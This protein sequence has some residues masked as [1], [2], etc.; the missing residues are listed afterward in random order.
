MHPTTTQLTE[1]AH[2]LKNLYHALNQLKHHHQQPEARVMKARPGAQSPGNWLAVSCYVEHEQRLREVA[3][4]AFGDLGVKIKDTQFHAIALCELIEQHAAAII[5]L[6]WVEDF[7]DELQAQE[8]VINR[9]VN[10]EARPNMR[11][12]LRHLSKKY[13]Q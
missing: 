13:G 11:R 1:T 5:T 6:E 2:S 4:N 3:L 12:V 8:T 10:P 7:W 9:R